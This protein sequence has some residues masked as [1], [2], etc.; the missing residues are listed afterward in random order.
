MR[1]SENMILRGAIWYLRVAVPRSLQA[2]RREQA[3]PVQREIWRSLETGSLKDAKAKAVHLKAELQRGFDEE[4][5]Q[6]RNRPEPQLEDIRDAALAFGRMVRVGLANERLET[7]PSRSE[8]ESSRI[9]QAALGKKMDRVGAG[10]P[11]AVAQLSR[12]FQLADILTFVEDAEEARAELRQQLTSDLACLDFTLVDP[13]VRELSKVR[14]LRLDPESTAYRQTAVLFMRAWMQE[15]DAANEHFVEKAADIVDQDVIRQTWAQPT[16]SPMASPSAAQSAVPTVAPVEGPG[17]ITEL[18]EEYLADRFPRASKSSLLERRRNIQ[19]FAEVAGDKPVTSYKKS[20][21][22]AFKNAL[23]KLPAHAGKKFAGLTVQDAIGRADPDVPRL[24]VKTIRLRLSIMGNFGKWL[25]ENVDGVN[26]DNFKVTAPALERHTQKVKEFSD[27]DVCAI[28]HSAAFT[29]C[30]SERNQTV[31]GTH[32]IRGYRFWLPLVAAFSGCRLNE[33]AQLRVDDVVDMNGIPVL[34]IT[35]RGEG[36]SLKTR[37]S[38]RLVPVHP[39]L[40]EVGF[41]RYIEKVKAK[42]KDLIFHDVPPDQQGRRS[43]VAGK[44]FRKFLERIGIKGDSDRGGFHRFRHAVVQKLREAGNL[45]HEIAM[46]IGHDTG[47]AKMTAGYGSSAQMLVS[48]RLVILG[49]LKYEGLDLTALRE[50]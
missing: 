43:T 41:L 10:H 21:M 40:I 34:R 42:G 28:F 1:K 22:L 12:Y 35:D 50:S 30:E 11:N 9:E 19:Q 20:D 4:A 27:A 36:Q 37:A 13:F 18:F 24:S 46:V 8:V 44:R 14:N 15:L 38:E 3:R 2:I 29:G 45:D 17:S 48:Q 31:P 47:V 23:A 25:A 16:V 33:I 39:E 5:R 7:F 26:A 6:H 32:R 49:Q